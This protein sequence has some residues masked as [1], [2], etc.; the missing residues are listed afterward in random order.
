MNITYCECVFVA[1]CMQ[2]AL[3]MRRVTLSCMARSAVQCSLLQF[4]C[5]ILPV[6]RPSLS[7]DLPCCS[8]YAVYTAYLNCLGKLQERVPH[9]R[10]MKNSTCRY[11]GM[12]VNTRVDLNILD[13][14]LWWHTITVVYSA[15]IE[16]GHFTNL[17]LC[18]TNHSQ[19]PGDC[20]S[21]DVS[22]GAFILLYP[23][24]SR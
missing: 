17:F 13:F 23:A 6:V 14:Y 4:H 5:H 15:P 24:K 3:R 16:N 22:V 1:L 11:I 8:L 12:S 20:P 21:S 2:H 7:H 18:L 19:P 9:T 10:G